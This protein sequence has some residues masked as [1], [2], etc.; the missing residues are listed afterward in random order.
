MQPRMIEVPQLN[1][2]AAESVQ[3][4]GQPFSSFATDAANSRILR[5]YVA[6]WTSR[7]P[8]ELDRVGVGK[9]IQCLG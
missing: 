7:V 6:D 2:F 5:G 9:A 4:R 3:Q 8:T 1:E